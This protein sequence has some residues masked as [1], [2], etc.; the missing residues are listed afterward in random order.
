MEG[1]K[2]DQREKSNGDRHNI[3]DWGIIKKNRK[4]A[5]RI[6]I[7]INKRMKDNNWEGVN[8]ALMSKEEMI[9]VSRYC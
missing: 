5:R 9:Y 2:I 3:I 8:L 7:E 1:N 4:M 6:T